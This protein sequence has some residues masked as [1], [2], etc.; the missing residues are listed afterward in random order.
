MW[1]STSA[2]SPKKAE[3]YGEF[4]YGDDELVECQVMNPHAIARMFLSQDE[5]TLSLRRT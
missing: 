5:G 4:D 1:I 2:H 3:S